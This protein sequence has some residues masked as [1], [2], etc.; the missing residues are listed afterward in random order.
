MINS[1]LKSRKL[2]VAIAGVVAILITNYTGRTLS[3]EQ[4]IALISPVVA[5][6]LGQS[7]VDQAKEK[8]NGNGFLSVESKKINSTS[9]DN[10]HLVWKAAIEQGYEGN[11]ESFKTLI[12]HL[13]IIN[14][15]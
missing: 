9:D 14:T 15:K 4:L 10:M 5:Y 12:S 3:T 13:S 8:A 11:Y 7:V 2:W 1:K 6:I